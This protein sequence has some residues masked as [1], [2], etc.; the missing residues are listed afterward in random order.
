M[1]DLKHKLRTSLIQNLKI[2]SNDLNFLPSGVILDIM[3]IYE[4]FVYITH[5]KNL[6]ELCNTVKQIF[7]EVVNCIN[8][9]SGNTHYYP[10]KGQRVQAM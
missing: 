3:L 6:E 8:Q 10:C 1:V 7:C 2:I 5:N 4:Y 9:Q